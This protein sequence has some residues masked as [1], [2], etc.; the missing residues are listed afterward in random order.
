MYCNVL[1]CAAVC[2]SLLQC[3][4]VCCSMLQSVAVRYNV[5]KPAV[6]DAHSR[7]TTPPT[8]AQ[9][10]APSP[11]RVLVQSQK[12]Q[13]ATKLILHNSHMANQLATNLPYKTATWLTFDFFLFASKSC[14]Y[15][16]RNAQKSVRCSVLQFVAVSVLQHVACSH[17]HCNRLQNTAT[18][19]NR[20]Q[21]TATHGN[22]QQHTCHSHASPCL[23]LFHPHLRL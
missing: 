2:C 9:H 12:H 4:A 13:L 23:R 16:A 6:V 3:V 11:A 15:A 21:R 10:L 14:A 8:H 7:G 5:T 18:H 1:Q 22:T 20:M 17:T 19:G